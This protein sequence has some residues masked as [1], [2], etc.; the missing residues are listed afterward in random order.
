MKKRNMTY[1]KILLVGLFSILVLAPV[2]VDAQGVGGL[3]IATPRE[4]LNVMGFIN[5]LFSYALGILIVLAGIMVLYA[6]FLYLFGG[7]KGENA[8]K[9]KTFLL[10]AAIAVTIGILAKGLV[11]VVVGLVGSAG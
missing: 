5:T 8:T 7:E 11:S 3:P 9:A 1:S 6:G 4:N 10:Y 2:F